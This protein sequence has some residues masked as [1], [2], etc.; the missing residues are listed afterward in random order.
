MSNNEKLKYNALK[1]EYAKLY[2]AY[3]KNTELL[4]NALKSI[5][6]EKVLELQSINDNVNKAMKKIENV[7]HCFM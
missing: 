2:V 3:V 7:E 5:Q 6:K 4:E 1:D